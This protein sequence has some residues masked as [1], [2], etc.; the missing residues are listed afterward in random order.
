MRVA[1]RPSTTPS[2]FTTNQSFPTCRSSASR[3]LGTCVRISP[4]T[5]FRLKI[6]SEC[7]L[8]SDFCQR[9]LARSAGHLKRKRAALGRPAANISLLEWPK[10]PGNTSVFSLR[11]RRGC[12]AS[13]PVRR[14][15]A[16][17]RVSRLVDFNRALEVRAVLDHDS[18]RGQVADY[19]AIL[20]NL[21]SVARSQIPFHVAVNHDFAGNNICRNF[22]ARANRQL[23]VFQLDQPFDCAVDVQIL[24]AGDFALNVQ[25]RT[26]PRDAAR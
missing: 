13:T 9:R 7:R 21:D 26:E 12:A 2:A 22:S 18:R 4:V 24:I 3:P 14:F 25:R 16:V 11:R 5:P 8:R 23:E 15:I 10:W 1:R 17:A 6:N 19:R 20:L